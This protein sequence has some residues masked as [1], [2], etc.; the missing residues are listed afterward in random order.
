MAK[1]LIVDDASY[2]RN[3]LKFMLENAGHSP[4]HHQ[5]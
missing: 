4:L 1:V 2:M 5:E 3:T